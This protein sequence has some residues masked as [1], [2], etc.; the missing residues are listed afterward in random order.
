MRA[1]KNSVGWLVLSSLVVGV[2]ACGVAPERIDGGPDAAA[3]QPTHTHTLGLNDV[4]WLL[5]LESLDAST[6]FPTAAQLLPFASFSRLT[7]AEPRVDVNLSRLRVVALRF[8]VCDRGPPQ[9]CE[10]GADG[11]FRVV[12]Q[13]VLVDPPAVEDIALHAFFPVPRADVP[14]VVDTLRGLAALQDV[15]HARALQVNDAFVNN[16]EYRAQL[17]AL[18]S[19]YAS[20]DR[21]VRLTLFGQETEHAAVV[22][23][24]R[25]EELQD[26]HLQ[27]IVIPSLDA[28]AQEVLLFGGDSFMPSPLADV[29]QGFARAA[30]ETTFR[31]ATPA[32]QLEAVRALERIDNPTLSTSNTV[33]C[34]SCHLTSTVTPARAGD[35]GIDVTELDEHFSSSEFDLTALGPVETRRRTMRN[36]GYFNAV[37]LVSTRVVNETVNTLRELR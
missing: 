20:A 27:P 34:A 7:S 30:M 6:P 17:G 15:P 24:F 2:S 16:A 3:W 8:D 37:P 4:T 22:W 13:P 25:G 19:R 28:G 11:I 29:P 36:L 26:G 1:L 18:V 10:A 5:P 33:Q 35:A 31:N 32:E 23:V 12:L 14:Q 21:L 9:P